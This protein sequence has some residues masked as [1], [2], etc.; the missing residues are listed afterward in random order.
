MREALEVRYVA[1]GPP[2]MLPRKKPESR[3][4]QTRSQAHD[5]Q[6]FSGSAVCTHP[7]ASPPK[8]GALGEEIAVSS[9]PHD[10]LASVSAASGSTLLRSTTRKTTPTRREVPR[11]GEAAIRRWIALLDVAD[12]LQTAQ[13]PRDPCAQRQA[14]RAINALFR[15]EHALVPPT[16]QRARERLWL[17]TRS[18]PLPPAAARAKWQ[19]CRCLQCRLVHSSSDT[20]RLGSSTTQ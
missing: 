16:R 19:Q 7:C 15:Y 9:I 3:S 20:V 10:D 1:R 4:W 12:Q 13:D 6:P 2:R 11:Q 5:P 18:E 8:S 17:R 14:G